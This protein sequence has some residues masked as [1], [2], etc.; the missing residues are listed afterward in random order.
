MSFEL[1]F[2]EGFTQYYGSL[3][4]ERAGL[5]KDTDYVKHT[6]AGLINTKMNTPG[7]KLYSPI[8]ASEEAVFTDAGVSIDKTNFPNIFSSY[9]PYGGSLALALD[10][11][12]REKYNKTLDDYM[13]AAWKKF[14]KPE[15]PYNVAG[16]QEVLAGVTDKKF[17]DTWFASYI[18]GHDPIDYNVLLAPAGFLLKPTEEGKAWIGSTR[19]MLEKEGLLLETGTL[20]GTPLYDA[21]VDIDD[22]IIGLDNQDVRT[23]ADLNTIL[24]KLHPG[25]TVTIRYMHRN[26][27]RNGSITLA[28]NPV[29]S[30]VTFEQAGRP[31]TPA[32]QEFRKHWLGAK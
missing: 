27:E 4:V 28:E 14:G 18:Y 12:L 24:A 5:S 31:V 32:I 9:Y 13:T 21:G 30:V 26:V 7:A 20:R 6:V 2:A 1:W 22:K 17:A 11:T 8:Q 19:A 29:V 16:L 23:F 25:A 10:L 3:L 15:I